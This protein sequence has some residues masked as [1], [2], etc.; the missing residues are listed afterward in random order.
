MNKAIFLDRDGTINVEKN[1]LYKIE[2]FEFLPGVIQGLKLLQDAGFLL[3]V[4]TNQSGIARGLYREEDFNKLNTW[5]LE[6]LKNKGINITHVYYCPHHPDAVIDLYKLDCEC[7]KPKIGMFRQAICDY[8]I[9]L[10][11]SYSIG[12]KL[13]DT[14]IR[15]YSINKC[16]LVGVNEKSEIINEVKN[17]KYEKV[18]YVKNFMDAVRDIIKQM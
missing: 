13:R 14:T 15:D 10:N 18:C 6:T 16:Y 7:R 2:D 9:D 11:Q 4:I 8:N 17:G 12:D 1:Y 5:M 3:I